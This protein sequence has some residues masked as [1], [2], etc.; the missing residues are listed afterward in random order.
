MANDEKPAEKATRLLGAK[1]IAAACDL[2]TDAVWKWKTQ[3]RGLIPA[4][5]QQTVL[6][7]ARSRGIA[8]TADELIG[9][10]Y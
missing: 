2:T 8:L 10:P 6:D 5:Y 7:L 3:G 4:R 9:E 1:C